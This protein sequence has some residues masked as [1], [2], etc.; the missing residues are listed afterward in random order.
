MAQISE[1][2]AKKAGALHTLELRAPNGIGYQAV[3]KIDGQEVKHVCGVS[4]EMSSTDFAKTTITIAPT[5]SVIEAKTQLRVKIGEREY[6][7]LP[8]SG[9]DYDEDTFTETATFDD[10]YT[11]TYKK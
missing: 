2:T 11:R 6:G 5:D 10:A 9:E 3:L 4:F 8:I 1:E 7:L